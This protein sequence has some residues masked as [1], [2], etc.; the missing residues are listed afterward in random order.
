MRVFEMDQLPPGYVRLAAEPKACAQYTVN[1]RSVDDL[2]A[3]RVTVVL[4]GRDVNGENMNQL[5]QLLK[6]FD[7]AREIAHLDYDLT[8]IP[9]ANC[10]SC[11]MRITN[12]Q[13]R[14]SYD[15]VER[16][17]MIMVSISSDISLDLRDVITTQTRKPFI[18]EHR[19]LICFR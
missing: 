12:P 10:R 5:D 4:S 9:E 16:Q 15:R 11:Y 8:N 19:V 14:L 7:V 17:L 6:T 1:A 2:K 13:T 3:R 18:K